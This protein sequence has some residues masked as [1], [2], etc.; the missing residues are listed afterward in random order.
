MLIRSGP[1]RRRLLP[2]PLSFAANVN[3]GEVE[4]VAGRFRLEAAQRA[5]QAKDA[6]LQHIRGCQQLRRRLGTVS[7]R[8]LSRTLRNLEFTGLIAR[9]VTGSKAIRVEYSLT[10]W[11]KTIIAP[12]GGMCRWAKRYQRVTADV[13]LPEAYEVQ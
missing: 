3:R 12:L 4:E 1:K 13:H 5:E 7:Q 2:R 9:R 11:G 8:M 10:R 6:A